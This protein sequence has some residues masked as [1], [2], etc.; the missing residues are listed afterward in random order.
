MWVIDSG[1]E[2]NAVKRSRVK[3]FT[4]EAVPPI[5][6]IDGTRIPVC[7]VVHLNIGKPGKE[8]S[9]L[10]FVLDGDV[11]VATDGILGLPFL[12][13][14]RC[15]VDMAH[16]RLKVGN[17]YSTALIAVRR[18]HARCGVGSLAEWTVQSISGWPDTQNRRTII[19]QRINGRADQG[20]G[21]ARIATAPSSRVIQAMDSGGARPASGHEAPQP[22]AGEPPGPSTLLREAKYWAWTVTVL[23][24]VTPARPS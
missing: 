12:V 1:S 4:P 14:A 19:V 16:K 8:L 3:S 7:G 13:G 11:S 24:G 23:T 21:E 5:C 17:L 9:Q 6:T 22:E 15:V 2:V 20:A 18:P 10:F